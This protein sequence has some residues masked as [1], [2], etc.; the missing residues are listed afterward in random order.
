MKM[1]EIPD[2]TVKTETVPLKQIQA[3]PL[4]CQITSLKL[5]QLLSLQ[6]C[7]QQSTR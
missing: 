4:L 1:E 6:V 7:G 3:Q 5:L 2:F